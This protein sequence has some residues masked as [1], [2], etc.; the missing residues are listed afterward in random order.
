MMKGIGNF[1]VA[2]AV[3]ACAGGARAQVTIETVTVGNPRNTGELS[4]AG[5]GGFGPDRICGAVD[6][7]Y[8]IGK[9]EVRAGRYTEFLNAVAKTDTC[10]LYNTSM[11]SS[12]QG[13]KIERTGSSPNYSYSVAADWADRPVNFVSWGDAARFANW[14]HNGQPAGAQDLTTTEDGSYFL[15]GATSNAALLAV[16]REPDATWVIPSEDEWYKAAYHKN[17]GVTGNYWDYPT[18][19]NSLPSHYL[20]DPD[21]G[22][23]ATFWN[24]GYTIG[25]PYYRTQVG[26]HENSDSPYGTFDQGG[27][28]WEWNEA[29]LH[30]SYR[31]VRGRSFYTIYV[32]TLQAAYRNYHYGP[33]DEG[34]GVGFRVAEVP[35]PATIA[36]LALGGVGVLGR[37]AR[38]RRARPAATR[39]PLNGAT[40][41]G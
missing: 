10:D 35:E 20:I 4:G 21:P 13:C 40:E 37:R 26:A 31:G 23:N 6:Y 36:L 11:W 39:P 38:V 14:L 16:V 27:N 41:G 19:T 7:V 9:F 28:V 17:D 29:V 32:V 8:N 12:S 33:A 34:Y 30:G 2:L 24:N 15:N 5:A 22:N 25:S 1:V 3:C 18:G